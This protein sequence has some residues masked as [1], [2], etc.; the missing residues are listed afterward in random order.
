MCVDGRP[1]VI[2][3]ATFVRNTYIHIDKASV[4]IENCAALSY[5][6]TILSA[7]SGARSA[8]DKTKIFRR[9]SVS[10]SFI[11]FSTKT[12][13]E[14]KKNKIKTTENKFVLKLKIGK[15]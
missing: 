5:N 4:M 3:K 1:D 9:E 11:H 13:N 15:T 7:W 2:E 12:K 14:K 10:D 8:R 6:L